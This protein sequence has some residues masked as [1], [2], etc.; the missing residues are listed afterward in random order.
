MDF[1]APPESGPSRRTRPEVETWSAAPDPTG[2][3]VV[4]VSDR[5][6]TPRAWLHD[7]AG[8]GGCG[9]GTPGGPAARC[10]PLPTGP[11]PVV[12]VSWSP[13]GDWIACVVAPGGSPV[14]EVWL[15]RPDGTGWHRVAGGDGTGALLGRWVP[16]GRLAVTET[17][18]VFRPMLVDPDTGEVSVLLEDRLTVLLDRTADGGLALL[19]GGPRG[20]RW[21]EVL[22]TASGARRRLLDDA[23]L[24]FFAADDR[25]VYARDVSG[26]LAALV[27]VDTAAPGPAGAP[28]AMPAGHATARDSTAEV[29]V[30]ARRP[31]AE[32]EDFTLAADRR[33]AA[34]LWNRYGGL[35]ELTVLDLDSREQRPA[36]PA[37]GE[38][39][40]EP[41]FSADGGTVCFTAQGPVQPRMVWSWE[42]ATGRLVP[43]G[44]DLTDGAD[45][46]D[47]VAP[48]LCDVHVPDGLTVSGWL[49]R[50]AGVGPWPTV[51]SLHGG[52][53]AQERP[54]WNPLFQDLVAAGMAV[55]APNVRGSSGFGRSFLTADNLAGRYG[56]IADVA[57][58]ARYLVA[59]G[60]AEPGRIACIGRSYGGYL[61][62]TALVTF[63][64]LFAAG[65]SECG[66]S[67]FATFYARTEPWIAAAAVSEYGDPDRDA[68]LL[69][70][71]SPVHK[72][73]R[74]TAPLL[75]IHGENDT[76]VPVYESRQVAAAL[77]DSPVP[78]ALLL[79]R[80]EGHDFLGAANRRTARSATVD[81]LTAYLCGRPVVSAPW[82]DQ[83]VSTTLPSGSSSAR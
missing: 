41:A 15:I 68:D 16:G 60:V 79:V 31:D 3:S 36:P 80:G 19:R 32:L 58:C 14:T 39:F 71:L 81:W 51:L 24:G 17:G 23:D 37:A 83:T 59:T 43:V 22:D 4:C 62:L 54:G 9:T 73:D 74:L 64:D 6:G 1:L 13:A 65:V 34:L 70:D 53:E 52:P 33:S 56:A 28:A 12:G 35:S 76:N 50:P 72:L 78:S 57:D 49:Y 21:L 8:T 67:N 75:L 7:H 27:L 18:E 20:A 77:T 30:L 10:R 29:V 45:S 66:M 26:E 38:V 44:D 48:Q 46:G 2:R 42:L 11:E 82:P 69:R 55:F 40:A 5:D 63:P 47:G 25:H 61:T